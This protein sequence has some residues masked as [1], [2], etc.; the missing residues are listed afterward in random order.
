LLAA[1]GLVPKDLFLTQPPAPSWKDDPVAYAAWQERER[2]RRPIAHRM[3]VYGLTAHDLAR[4]PNDR[5]G[6]PPGMA[7]PA[8]RT[9]KPRRPADA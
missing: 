3:S 2:C 9:R 4:P 5:A 7:K 6:R 1:A 8:K